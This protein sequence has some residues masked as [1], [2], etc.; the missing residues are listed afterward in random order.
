LFPQDS[1]VEEKDELERLNIL[2]QAVIP[3]INSGKKVDIEV[4]A[5][6]AGVDV[7]LAKRMIESLVG[8]VGKPKRKSE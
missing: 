3:I 1:T 7:S 5:T 4:L 6:E 2:M 8:K